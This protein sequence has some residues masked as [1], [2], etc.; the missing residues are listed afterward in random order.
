MQ[1]LVDVTNATI[2]QAAGGGDQ[3]TLHTQLPSPFPKGPPLELRFY[4]AKGQGAGYLESMF[5][6][7]PY[8]VIS[9]PKNA[10]KFVQHD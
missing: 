5:P 3:V 2:Y 7:I 9:Q 1:I 10:F 6:G 8:E 4:A